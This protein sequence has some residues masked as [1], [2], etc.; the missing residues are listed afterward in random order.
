MIITTNHQG[1]LSVDSA[2]DKGTVFTI[3]LP[4]KED[5]NE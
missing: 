3:R 1:M 4:Y 2:K 5:T